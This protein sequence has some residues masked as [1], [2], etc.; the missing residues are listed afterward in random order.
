MPKCNDVL[1][2]EFTEGDQLPSLV[3]EFEL[4]DLTGHTVFLNMFR[5]DGT[6]RKKAGIIDDFNVGGLL[7]GIVHF[8]WLPDDL[9][10]GKTSTELEIINALNQSETISNMF[11][12]V[13][14]QIA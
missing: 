1:V 5:P 10:A 8:D 4:Q 7:I 2:G 13:K 6:T 9:I 14:K 12:L 3:V 11:I